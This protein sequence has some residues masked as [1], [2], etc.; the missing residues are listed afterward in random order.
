MDEECFMRL[1]AR[2]LAVSG[3]VLALGV[4]LLSAVGPGR[5]D[6]KE[7]KDIIDAVNKMADSFQ[8]GDKDALKKQTE[9]LC[10]G[11][12]LEGIMELLKLRTKDGLGVGAKPGA[13]QPD[14]IEAKVQA[15]AKKELTA[16]DLTQQAADLEKMA[17]IIG[18]VSQAADYNTPKKKVGEKDPKDW[19]SWTDDMQSATGDLAKAIK[20]KNPKDIKTAASKLNGSCNNC[21]GVFRD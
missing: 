8:K 17:Y 2:V 12:P 3:V 7:K 6:E 9:D 1:Y 19:K 11:A 18:A 5:A 15:L 20:A 10:K 13:I 4:C 14:G 21:H 16:Q